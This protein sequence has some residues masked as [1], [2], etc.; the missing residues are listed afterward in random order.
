MPAHDL[1]NSVKDAVDRHSSHRAERKDAEHE[2]LGKEGPE[3]LG[4][5]ED[6]E[7]TARPHGH[8]GAPFA[9]VHGDG[10]KHNI[11]GTGIHPHPRH[12]VGSGSPSINHA[13]SRETASQEGDLR[14]F[15]VKERFLLA[16]PGGLA[17]GS[18]GKSLL[19]PTSDKQV[20]EEPEPVEDEG[21]DYA[22]RAGEAGPDR[23]SSDG[24]GA[25]QEL[26]SEAV[27]GA[28]GK[29]PLGE[30]TTGLWQEIKGT[31]TLLNLCRMAI[32]DGSGLG[33]GGAVTRNSDVKEHGRAIRKGETVACN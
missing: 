10:S 23:S 7:A 14:P 9:P 17:G 6:I 4:V 24:Q 21:R 33:G 25:D 22:P 13:E 12:S 20:V 16:D 29:V 19:S 8:G 15:F 26:S 30:Q 31:G 27:N 18:K 11:E 32:A 5:D 28:G 1:V 3:K 2:E